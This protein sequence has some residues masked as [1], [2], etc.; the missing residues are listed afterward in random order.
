MSISPASIT[1]PLHSAL[2]RKTRD[3]PFTHIS[4]TTIEPIMLKMCMYVLLLSKTAPFSF[5]NEILIGNGAIKSLHF[6]IIRKYTN[7]SQAKG[8]KRFH[9]AF[10]QR[11]GK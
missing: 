4:Y 2:L 8:M 6:E 10:L 11:V 5:Y 3:Q 1:A 9:I 7:D